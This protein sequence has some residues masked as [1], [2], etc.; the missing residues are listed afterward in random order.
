MIYLQ[1][2]TGG[3]VYLQLA[4][5]S[6]SKDLQSKPWYL[7]VGLVLAVLANLVW[8]VIARRE[9]TPEGLLIKG[10]IWDVLLTGCYLIIPILF[11]QVQLT[12]IQ[13][14]GIIL[15]VSGMILTKL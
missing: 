4:S 6:Y 13:I 11:Y 1:Y 10:L 14:F 15:I 7:P 8:L 3:L 9:P 12:L 5:L 2:L